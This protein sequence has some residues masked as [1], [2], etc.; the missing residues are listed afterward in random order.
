M[1]TWNH[2][3]KV[4]EVSDLDGSN[5]SPDVSFK[6]KVERNCI[7]QAM[8]T[9]IIQYDDPSWATL[10]FRLHGDNFAGNPG[11]LISETTTSKTKLELFEAVENGAIESWWE[12]DFV[13]LRSGI[14]YHVVPYSLDYAPSGGKHLAWRK[15]WPDRGYAPDPSSPVTAN[16]VGL[17]SYDVR[18]ITAD[19]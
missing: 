10:K 8:R 1:T 12:W 9:T 3:G 6:F 14:W 13:K 15:D 2:W 7:L 5:L 18:L 11:A 17:E 16:S 19:L 4:L